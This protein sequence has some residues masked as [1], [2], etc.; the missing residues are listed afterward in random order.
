MKVPFDEATI[1]R[2]W[3]NTCVPRK[4]RHTSCWRW[5]S[6]CFWDGYGR[7][8]GWKGNQ[9]VWAVRAH[10][11]SYALAFPELRGKLMRR[12]TTKSKY[13][14][15]HSCDEPSCV[16]P[17][18]LR[19]GSQKDN[20]ADMDAKGRRVVPS[21][22]GA[23][24]PMWGRTHTPEV[25]ERLRISAIGNTY[26]LGKHCST[27]TKQ[28]LRNSWTPERRKSA[29]IRIKQKPLG[30]TD[31]GRAKISKAMK[32]RPKSLEHRAKISIGLRGNKNGAKPRSAE[33]CARMAAAARNRVRNASGWVWITDGVCIKHLQKG[34]PLPLGFTFGRGL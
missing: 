34:L 29:S 27:E 32:D 17:E 7:F 26:R 14:V 24:N 12:K 22:R 2:F 3:R 15:L 16:N 1:T 9:R 31:A 30:L 4:D 18:H 19:V 6:E 23:N 20:V 33:T 10:I 8:S 5:T 11:Y 13:L 21:L 28:R 25:K